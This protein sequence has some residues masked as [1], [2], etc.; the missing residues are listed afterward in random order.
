[1][2][3][4]VQKIS[5]FIKKEKNDKEVKAKPTKQDIFNLPQNEVTDLFKNGKK[6]NK[7]YYLLLIDKFL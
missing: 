5:K 1:M 3:F 6:Q 7:T 2:G 4:D